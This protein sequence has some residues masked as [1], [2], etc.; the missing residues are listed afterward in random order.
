MNHHCNIS[1][2]QVN[3]LFAVIKNLQE[4]VAILEQ[5]FQPV[6]YSVPAG[7]SQD[8]LSSVKCEVCDSSVLHHIAH[9]HPF[10]FSTNTW[11]HDK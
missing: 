2:R 1:E 3:Y 10:D 6:K 11:W 4:K 5:R 8:Q 9:G 7:V